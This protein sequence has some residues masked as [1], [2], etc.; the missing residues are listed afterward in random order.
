MELPSSGTDVNGVCKDVVNVRM[1][2]TPMHCHK[3]HEVC[4]RV[5]NDVDSLTVKKVYM[6]DKR[7]ILL[8]NID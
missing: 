8:V 1:T 4:V 3:Q 7:N 5:R 6:S 2:A